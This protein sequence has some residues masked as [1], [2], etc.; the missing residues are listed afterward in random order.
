M[1]GLE[2]EAKCYSI[3]TAL[4]WDV[5]RDQKCLSIEGVQITPDF[6]LTKN[7]RAYGYAEVKAISDLQMKNKSVINKALYFVNSLKPD[8]FIFTNNSFFDLYL[9]GEYYGTLT[10]PPSPDDADLLLSDMEDENE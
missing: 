9:R 6:T 7:G 8:I 3:L 1:K 2:A 10:L 4:G 5:L